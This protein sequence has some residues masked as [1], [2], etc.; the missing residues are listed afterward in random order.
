MMRRKFKR[1]LTWKIIEI[2]M[3]IEDKIETNDTLEPDYHRMA[4]IEHFEWEHQTGYGDAWE[5]G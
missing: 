5:A 1:N 4:D 2:R 3:S